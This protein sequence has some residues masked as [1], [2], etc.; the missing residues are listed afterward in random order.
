MLEEQ[1]RLTVKSM[2]HFANEIVKGIDNVVANK[3]LQF[4]HGKIA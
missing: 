3:I 2:W 1:R 4:L